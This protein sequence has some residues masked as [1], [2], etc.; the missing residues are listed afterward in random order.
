[1]PS[2]GDEIENRDVRSEAPDLADYDYTLPA[3]RIAQ[4]P[5]VPRDGGRL[6]RLDRGTGEIAHGG[7][8]DLP[9]WLAPGD[10]LVVNTTRV[11]PARLPR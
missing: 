4:E 3:D 5:P 6:L 1:M 10:L 8:L 11:L 9:S 2:E 7:I